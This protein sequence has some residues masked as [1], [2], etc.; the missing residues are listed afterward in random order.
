M[1]EDSSTSPDLDAQ[2]AEPKLPSPKPSSSPV[3]APIPN[4][5]ASATNPKQT[6]LKTPVSV[7]VEH[8]KTDKVLAQTAQSAKDFWKKAQPVL[9]E[10]S[11]Q[12]L[13]AG[14]RFT[15]Q[16]LDQTW[17]KISRQAVAAVP[18]S[19]KAKVETQKA[20]LQPTLEKLQ[21]IWN[22]GILPAWRNFVVPLWLK[23]ID[24]LKRRLPGTLGAELTDR[25]LTIL[26]I[27]VLVFVYW[28]FSL[29]TG[30]QP[31]VAN[32]PAFPKPTA[33]PIVTRPIVEP[34]KPA[35]TLKPAPVIAQPS[36]PVKVITAAPI[37]PS[38]VASEPRS[39]GVD[40]AEIESQLSG[41]VANVDPGLIASVRS[42][43]DNHQLQA[44]LG[45]TWFGLNAV[46][47]DQVV[48]DLWKQSQ[49]LK[50]DRFELRDD[51]GDLIAR[52]PVVGSKAVVFK[53][54]NGATPDQ[55]SL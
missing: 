22:K 38:P 7:R 36:P 1:P 14:N 42:L 16:F 40:L 51:A 47:Q 21:P 28:F 3:P 23:G 5:S 4:V 13:R 18:D 8:S 9:R 33:A 20:K 11:I 32:Q 27:S 39:S 43:S 6:P 53:R 34:S 30:G 45:A 49:S 25:F 50:F 35:I 2:N 10:K 41:A 44:T 12:A 48:Q 46:A 15:N 29:L 24:L 37:Q 55:S 31:A 19:A 26:V 52:S 17:P 54:Q